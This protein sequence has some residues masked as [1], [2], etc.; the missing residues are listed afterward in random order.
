VFVE[1]A[2]GIE[3]LCHNSEIPGASERSRDE[4]PL[5]IEAE[6]DFKIIRLNEA[7]KKI[8]LEFAG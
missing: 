1:L 2:P 8:G 3:A 6:F 4:P 7:E 5:P